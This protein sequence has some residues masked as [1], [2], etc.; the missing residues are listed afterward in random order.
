MRNI[1][2]LQL[3]ATQKRYKHDFQKG[4]RESAVKTDEFALLD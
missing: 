3:T 1:I 4:E 2:H